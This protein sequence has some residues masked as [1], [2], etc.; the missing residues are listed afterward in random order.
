[1]NIEIFVLKN[2]VTN[3]DTKQGHIKVVNE[4]D[5]S[6]SVDLQNEL[7]FHDFEDPLATHLQPSRKVLFT[8]F[9]HHGVFF[10]WMFE[11][12]Y[13]RFIFVFEESMI[14]MFLNSHLMDN[15]YWHFHVF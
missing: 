10:K 13:L 7:I 6:F 2:D 9:L 14:K 8:T 11:F 4:E 3:Q 1:M 5:I 15:L 12:P